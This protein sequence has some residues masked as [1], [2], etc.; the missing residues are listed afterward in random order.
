[1]TTKR[2]QPERDEKNRPRAAGMPGD[3]AG[4]REEPGRTGVHP[5]SAGWPEG[6]MELVREGAWGQGDRGLAG[7]EDH[8]ES[9]LAS[10]MAPP[11]ESRGSLTSQPEAGSANSKAG[12]GEE[13]GDNA[14]A[15][16]GSSAGRPEQHG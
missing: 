14:D 6:E 5:A 11:G 2:R 9:E 15:P 12:N 13:A 3:G 1:M 8:G 10:G 7:Y 16:A 4:Q